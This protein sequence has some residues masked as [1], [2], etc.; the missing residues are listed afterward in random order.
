[1]KYF[2]LFLLL[3]SLHANAILD[4]EDAS[5]PELVTSARALAMGNAFM[6]KADDGWAAFYNPAG[7]GS[8]RGLQFHIFNLH[9]ES[10]AGF[11]KI[12]GDGP[13][14]DSMANY[15]SAFKATG[16]KALHTE[17]PGY[18]SHARVQLFPNVTYRGI[19]LGFMYVQ[20]NRARLRTEIADFEI[21][22]RIDSGPVFALSLSLFGGVVKFGATA[23]SLTRKELLKD[24]TTAEPVSITV[25]DDYTQGT[26]THI[27]GGFRLT[28]P[29]TALPTLSVVGRNSADV[30]FGLPEFSGLPTPIPA[31]M[32]ASLSI[33]PNLGKTARMHVEAGIK[34]STNAYE[35]VPTVRKT[36][37][38]VEFDYKRAMFIR[39]GYGDGWGS[40]GVGARSKSFAFDL[41]SY[42][43]EG[44]V[45]G[46]R[47]EEDRRFA[48]SFSGGF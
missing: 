21:G 4:F 39:F 41:T 36:V 14:T 6:G 48:I 3:F 27:T 19:S 31:T 7:L 16:L 44:S 22:E 1:M 38:G 45:D 30:E 9:L 43:I 29:M 37:L 46:V 5:S 18:T 8:V 28:V 2:T 34:D 32:D 12:T 24:F 11:L 40:A 25:D 47:E 23:I 35:S 15:T 13:F 33:T 42:A 17:N 20:Q 26:M 10:N